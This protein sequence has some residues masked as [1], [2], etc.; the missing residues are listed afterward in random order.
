MFESYFNFVAPTVLKKHLYEIKSKKESDKLVNI[1]KSGLIDSKNKI[2]EMS[3]DQNKI[4]KQDKI[5]KI[6]EEILEFNE[7]EKV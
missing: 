2:K 3:E 5:L 4:E 1:I 6:G 7:K